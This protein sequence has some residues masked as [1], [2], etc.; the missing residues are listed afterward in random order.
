MKR[1]K[2]ERVLYWLE[3]AGVVSTSLWLMLRLIEELV[4]IPWA[5]WAGNGVLERLGN[6]VGVIIS[7]PLWI[8]VL[9]I[10]HGILIFLIN[11]LYPDE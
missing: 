10:I 11:K 5:E 2:L 7:I 8:F 4:S 1:T 6:V 3:F 9:W